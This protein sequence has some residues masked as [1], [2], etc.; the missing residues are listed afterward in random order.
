MAIL[1][2]SNSEVPVLQAVYSS[3][4]GL[5]KMHNPSVVITLADIDSNVKKAL[6][7]ASEM[8]TN[9]TALVLLPRPS[10]SKVLWMADLRS[11]ALPNWNKIRIS[12]NIITQ[13]RAQSLT[14]L[15]KALSDAYYIGDEIP[16]SF[17]MDS[18]VDEETIKLV[19]SFEW[20]HGPKTMRRRIIQ[21]RLIPAVSESW[22]PASDDDYGILLEDNIEVSSYYYLWIKYTLLAYHSTH[23]FPSPNSH[24]S[25]FTLPD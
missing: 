3:M 16:I 13:N 23:K 5:I 22:Y 10:V 19:D 14:R 9:G 11:T 6:K 4:R 8:N 20:P 25:L 15:L 21:G 1:V 7:I 18:K 17:N 12:I 24:R 2:K